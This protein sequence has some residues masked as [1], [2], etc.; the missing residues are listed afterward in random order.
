VEPLTPVQGPVDQKE[1]GSGTT[2]PVKICVI[3]IFGFS[4]LALAKFVQSTGRMSLNITAILTST[5]KNLR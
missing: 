2:F 5:N 4:S 1:D 3:P